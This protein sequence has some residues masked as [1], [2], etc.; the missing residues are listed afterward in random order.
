MLSPST[1]GY[2]RG[3]KFAHYRRL[4]SLQEYVLVAQDRLSIERYTRNQQGQWLLSEVNELEQQLP[5]DAINCGLL[6]KD[7]YEKVI[8]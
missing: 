6:V 1:E 7:V 3:T 8:N 5:L 4:A 2:D